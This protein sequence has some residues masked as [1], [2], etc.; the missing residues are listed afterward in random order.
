MKNLILLLLLIC[1]FTLHAANQKDPIKDVKAAYLEIKQKFNPDEQQF[2]T[3]LKNENIKQYLKDTPIE[4]WIDAMSTSSIKEPAI[5][6]RMLKAEAVAYT[7]LDSIVLDISE[8]DM[9][10]S[11]ASL[12]MTYNEAYLCN[13][14]TALVSYS[15][16]AMPLGAVQM[17]Y[18]EQELIDTLTVLVATDSSLVTMGRI[19]A[20]YNE[21]NDIT[22]LGI[23]IYFDE[24]IFENAI[25]VKI[26]YDEFDQLSMVEV[27]GKEAIIHF[28]ENY[29]VISEDSLVFDSDS[30]LVA[31]AAIARNANND[32]TSIYAK[33]TDFGDSIW[34]G[35][36]IGVTYQDT[37]ITS[38][39]QY[40]DFDEEEW[41]L[42]SMKELNYDANGNLIAQIDSEKRDFE[43][44]YT[45]KVE[46]T[47]QGDLLVAYY[48]SWYDD[49]IGEWAY[50]NKDTIIYNENNMV[51]KVI[52]YDFMFDEWIADDVFLY[53]FDENEILTDL[54]HA[55][56]QDSQLWNDL[57]VEFTYST[58]Q[59]LA[60]FY[61]GFYGYMEH[62]DAD[63]DT[64][65]VEE[66]FHPAIK[67]TIIW[68]DNLIAG[69][70][71]Y[72]FDE[73]DSAWHGAIKVDISRDA[74][75]NFTGFELLS[76][77]DSISDWS[78]EL[79]LDI[80]YD[81]TIELPVMETPELFSA[82]YN[83]ILIM[84]ELN[85]DMIAEMGIDI[86]ETGLKM[87]GYHSLE[88]L[89]ENLQMN[90]TPTS[91][92]LNIEEEDLGMYLDFYY[93]KVDEVR[94]NE[95]ANAETVKVYPNPAS[96]IITI[97]TD[98]IQNGIINIYDTSGKNVM[99]K[100]LLQTNVV[101]IS[102]LIKGLYLYTVTSEKNQTKGKLIVK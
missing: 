90:N 74:L 62:Y 55:Y 102:S 9:E 24:F 70:T 78:D 20:V 65:I 46:F 100:S 34:Y 95:F 60:A 66:Y 18:N 11:Q 15:D 7:L 57:K 28:A 43:M 73:E 5:Q 45:D 1:A 81:E 26:D 36:K 98:N 76:W 71:A 58:N 63:N 64:T 80:A 13:Q 31:E 101:N 16:L 88:E 67:D 96:N 50:N 93:R 83:Q 85:V 44:V 40:E 6:S 86:Q 89:A 47:Y 4:F 84:T 68:A 42:Y 53:N 72:I 2:I 75:E 49:F 94:V 3:L 30:I 33:Y 87:L 35:Y 41:I 14:I 69:T 92:A 27:F 10:I 8:M 19:S 48:D 59:R 23:S 29:G 56:N 22:Q 37:L 32:I 97:N 52:K 21:N 54:T 12:E 51:T 79:Q 82:F 17:S 99:Q 38:I 61:L 25:S 77:T 91:V 39:A